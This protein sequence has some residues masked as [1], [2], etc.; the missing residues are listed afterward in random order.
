MHNK[1]E[2]IA[3]G[4]VQFPVQQYCHDTYLQKFE[5][6]LYLKKMYTHR[7]KTDMHLAKRMVQGSFKGC[8]LLV[9]QM[10]YRGIKSQTDRDFPQ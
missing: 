7:F 5:C 10:L 8:L 3:K 1:A 4:E 2:E 6:E 9:W